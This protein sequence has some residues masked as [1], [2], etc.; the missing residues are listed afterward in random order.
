LENGVGLLLGLL[1]GFKWK[2]KLEWLFTLLKK[3]L[4]ITK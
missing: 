3:I 1:D 2:D 4:A